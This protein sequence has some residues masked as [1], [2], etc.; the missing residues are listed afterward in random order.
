MVALECCLQQL[1]PKIE[2]LENAK[3][4]LIWCN[5]VQCLRRYVE[6]VMKVSISKPLQQQVEDGNSKATFYDQHF[7]D[8]SAND[9]HDVRCV[10][11]IYHAI[12]DFITISKV[13]VFF[14]NPEQRVFTPNE[15]VNCCYYTSHESN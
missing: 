13:A 1:E 15:L 2:E 5:Q 11:N 4:R 6:Q 10:V 3:S 14:L 9:F 8:V 7:G 12:G